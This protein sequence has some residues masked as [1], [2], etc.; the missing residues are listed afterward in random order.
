MTEPS[1]PA[2]PTLPLGREDVYAAQLQ[3]APGPPE[4]TIPERSPLPSEAIGTVAENPATGEILM[5]SPHGNWVTPDIFQQLTNPDIFGPEPGATATGAPDAMGNLAATIA[6]GQPAQGPGLFD[7]AMQKFGQGDYGGAGMDFAKTMW[8][9]PGWALQGVADEGAD[10]W[11]GRTGE[12]LLSGMG[13]Y[14]ARG[15][16]KGLVADLPQMYYKY[17]GGPLGEATAQQ[18]DESI[19]QPTRD[20]INEWLPPIEQKTPQ[21]EAAAQLGSIAIPVV[22]AEVGATR[23]AAAAPELMKAGIRLLSGGGATWLVA[24][25]D[26]HKPMVLPEG[27]IP[28]E[29]RTNVAIEETLLNLLGEAGYQAWRAWRAGKPQPEGSP[30]RELAASDSLNGEI[31]PPEQPNFT[32]IPGGKGTD[33]GPVGQEPRGPGTNWTY[34]PKFSFQTQIPGRTATSQQRFPGDY[35]PKIEDTQIWPPRDPF[36]RNNR[37]PMDRIEGIPDRPQLGYT[38]TPETPAEPIRVPARDNAQRGPEG[39]GEPISMP[40]KNVPY[41]ERV[42]IGMK[43]LRNQNE[44]VIDGIGTIRIKEAESGW[45]VVMKDER[46]GYHDLSFGHKSR[47]DAARSALYK[48]MQMQD[49][50]PDIPQWE[51]PIRNVT[52]PKGEEPEVTT[53][54]EDPAPT[55]GAMPPPGATPGAAT[56]AGPWAAQDEYDELEARV[57]KDLEDEGDLDP[58]TVDAIREAIIRARK[59]GIPFEEAEAAIE[60]MAFEDV[61]TPL[62]YA[63]VRR[64]LEDLDLITADNVEEIER[65]LQAHADKLHHP[66]HALEEI[67]QFIANQRKGIEDSG[68]TPE[69][70][71]PVQDALTKHFD[72]GGGFKTIV[73]ARKFADEV[74]GSKT[75]GGTVDAKDLEEMIE[76]AVVRSARKITSSTDAPDAFNPQNYKF[77]KLVDLYKRQPILG[78][79]TSSSAKNQA[80]STPAPLAYAASRLAGVERSTKVYEPSAGTGMLLIDTDPDGSIVN[81]LNPTRSEILGR[82]GF[83]PTT[84]DA[85]N[86][87]GDKD[88]DVV[89]ANP[90]FGKLVDYDSGDAGSWDMGRGYKTDQ[91]DHAIALKA[92]DRMAD[93]GRAVLILGGVSRQ[94]KSDDARK[95]AYRGLQKRAFYK[96][97]YEDYNVTDHFTV[98]GEMYAKQGAQWPVDVIQI[99]GRGKS[100]MDMP[101]KTPPRVIGSWDDLKKVMNDGDLVG[102]RPG[103]PDADGGGVPRP[104]Q[105]ENPTKPGTDVSGGAGGTSGTPSQSGGSG[106]GGGSSAPGTSPDGPGGRSDASPDKAPPSGSGVSWTHGN[107][108]TSGSSSGGSSGSGTPSTGSRPG[109]GGGQSGDVA[110]EPSRPPRDEPVDEELFAEDNDRDFVSHFEEV[111]RLMAK[112]KG[113]DERLPVATNWVETKGNSTGKEWAITMGPDGQLMQAG[114]SNNEFSVHF[115]GHVMQYWNDEGTGMVNIHHHPSS[116]GPS[117][118]DAAVL[119]AGGIDEINVTTQ[120]GGVHTIRAGKAQREA[121]DVTATDPDAKYRA[122]Q[123]A[124]KEVHDLIVQQMSSL[125]GASTMSETDFHSYHSHMAMETLHRLG[126]ID[127]QPSDFIIGAMPSIFDDF[128][129]KNINSLR[130][131]LFRTFDLEKLN[132][133]PD[134]L[135]VTKRPKGDLGTV[136]EGTGQDG[137]DTLA[138]EGSAGGG[139]KAPR[140]ESEPQPIPEK[141]KL[142]AEKPQVPYRPR[143]RS[144]SVDTLL[145][146]NLV[147]P[148]EKALLRIED[149]NGSVD[150]FVAKELDYPEGDLPKYFSAEQVDALAM[151]IDNMKKGAALILGDQTGIG[152]GRVVAGIQRWAMKNGKVPIFVTEDPKLYKNMYEDFN[153]IGMPGIRP[154]MTNKNEKVPLDEDGKNV[155]KTTAKH[156]QELAKVMAHYAKEGNLGDYD[157]IFTNYSQMQTV[158]GRDTPRRRFLLKMV[159]NNVIVF[160]ESHN[161]GGSQG[162][163]KGEDKPMDR[164]EIARALVDKAGSVMYSSATYA[165]RPDVMDLYRKTDMKLA[166][167]D[168]KQLANAISRGGVPMQQIVARMLSE[169]GQYIRRER[170]FDGVEYNT[171]GVDV[172]LKVYDEVAHSL[173]AI[174][175]FEDTYIKDTLENIEDDIANEGEA[176]GADGAV[177]EAGMNST[178]F[179]SV[180]H[181]LIDQMLLGM[182]VDPAVDRAIAALKRGEKPIITVSNTMGA[183]IDEYVKEHDLQGG[184]AIDLTMRDLVE[185]YLKRTRR[186]T[187]KDPHTEEVEEHYITDE[188]LGPMG[189]QAY[190]DI[191]EQIRGMDMDLPVSPIDHIKQR[192]AAEG[193]KVGEITGRTSTI[194]YAP[195]KAGRKPEYRPR[196]A[197]ERSIE[198]KNNTISGFNNGEIDVLIINR[199]GATGVSMHASEK[200]K[201]Q[202]Q[203]L[204]ILAQAE[205][206]IDTH[207]QMLG[208]VHRTGQVV[209]PKYEQ[210]VPNIPA[211]K[212]PAAVLAKKMASLN[213][214]TTASRKGALEADDVPDFI[215]EVGDY[216]AFQVMKDNRDVWRAMGEPIPLK[217]ETKIPENAMTR[218]TGKIPLLPLKLQEDLYELL[219][220]EYDGRIRSLEAQGQNP[221]EAKA[222]DL[223]AVVIGRALVKP[224]GRTNSPFDGPVYA[225]RMNVKRQAKPLTTEQVKKELDEYADTQD[226]RLSKFRD[227]VRDYDNKHKEWMEE[228]VNAIT[229]ESLKGK[230]VKKGEEPKDPETLAKE[231]QAQLRMDLNNGRQKFGSIVTALVPGKHVILKTLAGENLHGV[232][233]KTERNGKAKNPLAL[234]AW[235]TTVAFITGDA[236]KLEIPLSQIDVV[237]SAFAPYIVA[238]GNGL[239][240]NKPVIEVFDQVQGDRREDRIMF[241][242]NLLRGYSETKGKG[243]IVTFSDRNGDVRE[244]ILMP[245]SFSFEKFAKDMEVML[246]PEKALEWAK[247]GNTVVT[248]DG[249]ASVFSNRSFTE[250]EAKLKKADGGRYWQSSKLI[251]AMGVEFVK[252]GSKYRAEASTSD[253]DP[254]KIM[255]ILSEI[256]GGLT[257]DPD[258]AQRARN[259]F[260]ESAVQMDEV[261]PPKG[262]PKGDAPKLEEA[263]ASLRATQGGGGGKKPPSDPPKTGAGRS[264]ADPSSRGRK[265]NMGRSKQGGPSGSGGGGMGT[266]TLFSNPFADPAR[267]AK[268]PGE[269]VAGALMGFTYDDEGNVVW[270]PQRALAYGVGVSIA[271][272]VPLRGKTALGKGSWGAQVLGPGVKAALKSNPLTKLFH[273]TNGIS[274]GLFAKLQKMRLAQDRGRMD[275]VKLGQQIQEKLTPEERALASNWRE[276]VNFPD[277]HQTGSLA[278]IPQHVRDVANTVGGIVD[279]WGQRL[280]DVGMLDAKDI[281]KGV[282]SYLHRYYLPRTKTLSRLLRRIQRGQK[283]SVSGTY[284]RRRGTEVQIGGKWKKGE[285]VFEMRHAENNRARYVRREEV[286]DFL[287]KGYFTAS[288]FEVTSPTRGGRAKIWRDW[289]PMERKQM[290]EIRDISYRFTKS[291]MEVQHDYAL[292]R[293]FKE[294]AADS[295]W[296]AVD[297]V[298]PRWVKVPDVNVTKTKIKKYGALAGMYVHPEVMDMLRLTRRPWAHTG[299]EMIDDFYKGYSKALGAWKVG[300]TAYNPG[301]HVNNFTSNGVLW[302]TAV[303]SNIVQLGA[304]LAG[305]IKDTRKIG[306]GSKA[307]RSAIYEEAQRAGLSLDVEVNIGDELLTLNTALNLGDVKTENALGRLFNFYMNNWATK[308]YGAEDQIFKLAYYKRLRKQGY[309]PEDA[310]QEVHK[311]FFDYRDVPLGVQFLRDFHIPF[312]TYTYKAVP[313]IARIAV[314]Q[315][316]RMMAAFAALNG[317][318]T[319]MYWY[320][321]D[322]RPAAKEEYER[323]MLPEWQ[324]GISAFGSQRLIRLPWNKKDTARPGETRAMFLNSRYFLPGGDIFELGT[325]EGSGFDVPWWPAV[326][327]GTPLGGNPLMTTLY[328]LATGEDSFTGREIYPH[329]DTDIDDPDAPFGEKLANVMSIAGYMAHQALPPIVPLPGAA[330]TDRFGDALVAE[331]IVSKDNPAATYMNWTGTDYHGRQQSLTRAILRTFAIKIEELNPDEQAEYEE[332]RLI[333]EKRRAQGKIYKAARDERNND[334][335]VDAKIDALERTMLKM[336]KKLRRTD[337]LRKRAKD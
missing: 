131:K 27:S 134:R 123:R 53:K 295:E 1:R 73:E 64:F 30:G 18:W 262:K 101:M 109:S 124:F 287:K 16:G 303:D 179:T 180:M 111:A 202:R 12:R 96:R 334:A 273:P 259:F 158:K 186:Y 251:E 105:P 279:D 21:A 328:G 239:F 149:E 212:R 147:D 256:G 194:D 175:E 294:I 284:G 215:N 148:V 57:L 243:Q 232:V 286:G 327:G 270:S 7:T 320:M 84:D 117:P 337:E 108:S 222:V 65:I 237:D 99:Q 22:G 71:T 225:E 141:R 193:Y 301:T 271:L 183:F 178:N 167:D 269:I 316:H 190:N 192:L 169:S 153:D 145:P 92:L 299:Y 93:D 79:R 189:L 67:Q 98:P 121:V 3:Y 87:S 293:M 15:V 223:D 331:G 38:P 268:V 214:N 333:G 174:R 272:R 68:A 281:E 240:R 103:K 23:L 208:R 241:T 235:K 36:A 224:K 157:A 305:A 100:A 143:S 336:E 106:G 298:D 220:A 319:G 115:T 17:A 253:I 317:I 129:N 182:T 63:S 314:E 76:E 140:P 80:F 207:M 206:N 5:L 258:D 133:R 315:P 128:L 126:I 110:G 210:L 321:F 42:N 289:T 138:G 199:S 216:V 163:W 120:S 50:F 296:A 152:K 308:L 55:Q 312:I 49:Q 114:T 160:D 48:L 291:L 88:V 309:D 104:D 44:T 244:G 66:R 226:A 264:E 34:P 95:E 191:L 322:K 176:V 297:Q 74:T 260:G 204:M 155:L 107:T 325:P 263:R 196:P 185:R 72:E 59:L 245:Q 82:Q 177:G 250:V 127:Y 75:K 162:D 102:T 228:Q 266:G 26:V 257:V 326:L 261:D 233:L 113:L 146:T 4:P 43:T 19:G 283:M 304:D 205:K 29:T 14:I 288:K 144:T 310:V 41:D 69:S 323:H 200:F 166:V 62:S 282:G 91:I 329:P 265:V 77:D 219:E 276:G 85:M 231:R 246:K 165:K 217:D 161:A 267:L 78:T 230:K 292:G 9:L 252:K 13:R 46:G 135:S 195:V 60:K 52:P 119:F 24:D 86:I 255:K 40:N 118:Q 159:E 209:L 197:K 236:P 6:E 173:G 122:A 154:L 211:A 28:G 47:F 172:D 39:S 137:S 58:D 218:V 278:D 10:Y 2:V 227:Y 170:S 248:R 306:K 130:Q 254:L 81:E 187:T 31:L 142:S 8:Q 164:A 213:A 280:V 238:N 90:P 156:D 56:G 168:I 234:G 151:S 201:D 32:Q 311:L 275:A 20:F 150:S 335:T 132:E 198:G 54:P 302:M 136:P 188:E 184:S 125:H 324:E 318:N 307:T 181:N 203:R 277:Q 171:V 229:P 116:S 332:M 247:A 61:D 35:Q 300:K 51:K 94:A 11:T 83:K 112:H 37:D 221:L 285:E 290:G 89:I 45:H 242:G 70:T 139:E 274:D 313:A 25:P 33:V 249:F 330:I 97:L